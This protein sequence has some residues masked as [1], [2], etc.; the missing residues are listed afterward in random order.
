MIPPIEVCPGPTPGY[1]HD[2]N[3]PVEHKYNGSGRIDTA[4]RSSKYFKKRF[5]HLNEILSTS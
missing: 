2:K 5:K 1:L 4:E 3:G